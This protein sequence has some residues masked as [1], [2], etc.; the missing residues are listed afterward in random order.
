MYLE[1]TQSPDQFA[2]S[3]GY[4]ETYSWSAFKKYTLERHADGSFMD[5]CKMMGGV[6]NVF[7]AYFDGYMDKGLQEFVF[8]S[9][10]APEVAYILTGIRYPQRSEE[11]AGATGQPV[12]AA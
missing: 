7:R 11:D 8:I 10:L 12:E 6:L 4:I 2:D 3:I 9:A 5:L 1:T